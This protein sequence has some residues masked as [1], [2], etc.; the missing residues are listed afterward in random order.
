MSMAATMQGERRQAIRHPAAG[1][2][3]CYLAIAAAKSV[4]PIKVQDLSSGGIGLSLETRLTLPPVVKVH[5]F[6]RRSPMRVTALGR[7]VYLHR[8][9][10]RGTFLVGCRFDQDL[11]AAEM[12]ALLEYAFPDCPTFSGN[13]ERG[14]STH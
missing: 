12:L 8:E 6:S 1:K 5:L 10:R 11:K 13:G 9:P 4:G 2:V 14:V 7:V 3:Y